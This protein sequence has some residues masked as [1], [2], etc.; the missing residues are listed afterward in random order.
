MPAPAALVVPLRPGVRAAFTTRAGGRSDGPYRSLNLGMHVGDVPE[1]VVANRAAAAASLGLV[2]EHVA[3]A[4][5]VHGARVAV[6]DT[7]VPGARR[8]AVAGC[9]AMVSASAGAALAVLTAD[10]VPLLLAAPGGLVGAVHAGRRGLAAGV[11]ET[12][13]AAM[14]GAA[15]RTD[16]I[17]AVTGPAIGP[18]CYEVGVAVHD[19]VTSRIPAAAARSRGG[20]PALDL[21]AGVRAV[22][23]GLGVA[24]VRSVGGCTACAPDSWF[25]YRR[26]G[27]TGRMGAYVW[28]DAG[29]VT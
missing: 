12:A 1:R 29:E 24:D 21:V 16:D 5:Q 10:C 4:E 28:A 18:C 22:L 3:W 23:A 9:D 7:A 2:A 27:V 11:V 25:S 8:D 20:R 19:E 17:A 6:V 15:S 13:V 14:A 26:D